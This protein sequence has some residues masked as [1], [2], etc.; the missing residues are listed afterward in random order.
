[1]ALPAAR[2]RGT[3]FDFL[4]GRQHGYGRRTQAPKASRR[5]RLLRKTK[6]ALPAQRQAGGWS[7]HAH[8]LGPR[9]LC[10][11]GVAARDDGPIG[12]LVINNAAHHPKGQLEPPYS[13]SRIVRLTG[14]FPEGWTAQAL[15]HRAPDAEV[16]AK[17]TIQQLGVTR[18]ASVV[19][20]LGTSEKVALARLSH[21]ALKWIKFFMSGAGHG[22]TGCA[23]QR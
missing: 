6:R 19:S 1:M 5:F 8:S 22:G 21:E 15:I 17:L 7:T 18:R 2:P 3:P 14:A 4:K 9:L 12:V 20:D 23:A 10:G 13:M 16:S 11:G